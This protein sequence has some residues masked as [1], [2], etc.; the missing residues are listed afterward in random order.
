MT[1]KLNGPLIKLANC[2]KTKTFLIDFFFANY[3]FKTESIWLWLYKFY[4]GDAWV[5]IDAVVLYADY[6]FIN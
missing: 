4:H 2:F 5:W 6:M 3:Y 1:E